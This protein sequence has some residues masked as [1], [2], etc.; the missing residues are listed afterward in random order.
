MNEINFFLIYS[1]AREKQDSRDASLKTSEGNGP[2][3]MGSKGNATEE[4]ASDKVNSLMRAVLSEGG[5][6]Q[7]SDKEAQM[8]K[9]TIS[10]IFP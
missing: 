2:P 10:S 1:E 9:A 5:S 7:S 8:G 4:T 3:K 6:S